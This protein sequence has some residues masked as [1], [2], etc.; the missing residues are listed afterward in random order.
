MTAITL[1]QL[2]AKITRLHHLEK[3]W[4]FLDYDEHDMIE[5]GRTVPIPPHRSTQTARCTN[6]TRNTEQYR[7]HRDDTDKYT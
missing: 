7:Y 5:G 1:K 4:I 6:N 3:K 2:K